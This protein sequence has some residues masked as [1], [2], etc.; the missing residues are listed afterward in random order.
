MGGGI[1]AV[2]SGADGAGG[3]LADLGLGDG[4]GEGGLVREQRPLHLPQSRE[5]ETHTHTHTH[6]IFTVG[7]V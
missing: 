2:P 1:L 7:L 5:H 4:G 6:D 3:G